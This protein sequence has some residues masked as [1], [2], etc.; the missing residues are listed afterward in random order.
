MKVYIFPVDTDSDNPLFLYSY[1][2]VYK[3]KMVMSYSIYYCIHYIL[4]TIN[5]QL[6]FQ[7]MRRRTQIK[8]WDRFRIKLNET[9]NTVLFIL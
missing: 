3:K 6:A 4:Y 8:T 2:S 7:I 5:D 9:N 1:T